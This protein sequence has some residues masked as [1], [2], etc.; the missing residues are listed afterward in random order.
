[1]KSNDEV[2]PAVNIDELDVVFL[3]YQEPNKEEN[4]AKLKNMCPWAK[5]V[6]GVQGS[7]NAHKAAARISETERFILIDGDNEVDASF[8]DEQLRITESNK[9]H[10]MRWRSKNSV[11]NLYYGN[12]GVSSWT[13]EFVMN[14]KTHENSLGDNL[15]NIEFCFHPDYVPYY[16]CYSTT[17]IN[18]SSKQ[19]FIAAFREGVK[20]CNRNGEMPRN[21]T[22]FIDHL[23]P[24]NKRNLQL[25]Q[26]VGRDVEN[27]F[28]A[29]L[30]SR[31][32][33][34]YLMLSEWDYRQVQDF[35]C[36]DAIWERHKNDDEHI[37]SSVMQ[38]LNRRLALG[39]V[40]IDAAASRF[41]K[42]NINNNWQ[43]RDIM[44]TEMSVIREQEGW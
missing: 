1:M 6:D 20:M 17:H 13:R 27:G 7:D 15:T 24:K 9:N 21:R 35:R 38:E 37:A 28:W 26:T 44:T 34:H 18:S 19:A 8:F 12:G 31:L 16:N 25:W 23:W 29:I 10:Q 39:I 32:G 33:T 2:I 36:L 42:A 5:R 4:W 43:N 40:D 11:N 30:G 14:M 3:S 41:F 22:E